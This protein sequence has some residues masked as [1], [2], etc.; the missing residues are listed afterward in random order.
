MEFK[1][2]ITSTINE[3]REGVRVICDELGISFFSDTSLK[4]AMLDLYHE[5]KSL[6]SSYEDIADGFLSEKG[7]RN[8][9]KLE[10]LNKYLQQD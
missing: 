7:V 6:A 5:M 1:V 8:R 2:T 4:E 3:S 10:E 9:V